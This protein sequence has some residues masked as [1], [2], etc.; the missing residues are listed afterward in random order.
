MRERDAALEKAIAEVVTRPF[1]SRRQKAG[2]QG[3]PRWAN[4]SVSTRACSAKTKMRLLDP[5][6]AGISTAWKRIAADRSVTA[7]VRFGSRSPCR[8]EI[9]RLLRCVLSSTWLASWFG[10]LHAPTSVHAEVPTR[11]E[12]QQM[13]SRIRKVL[14]TSIML[15]AALPLLAQ[16]VP[17]PLQPIGSPTSPS[18]TISQFNFGGEGEA[19]SFMIGSTLVTM[20]PGA[21]SLLA[22]FRVGDAVQVEGYGSTTSSG[23]QRIEPTRIVN[24]ARGVT[25]TVPTPGSETAWSGSGRVAQYNYSSRGEGDGLVLD[26]GVLVRTPPHFSATLVGIAPLGSNVSVTGTAKQTVLGKTVV[27][28]ATVNGMTVHNAPP[29]PPAAKPN[30]P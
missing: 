24:A 5:P 25:V 4:F 18:G 6:G 2:S 12:K 1:T 29:P 7:T 17:P 30:S 20:P 26:S 9:G 11:Q 8:R 15:A 23:F 13:F 3:K 21:A 28:A 22:S 14:T 16:P 19:R 10:H 27:N